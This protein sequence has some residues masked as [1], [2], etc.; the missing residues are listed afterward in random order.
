MS[1]SSVSMPRPLVGRRQGPL[2]QHAGDMALIIGR[3]MNAAARID[4]QLHEVA[5]SAIR[6]GSICR[7]ARTRLLPRRRP[8]RRRRCRDRSALRVHH[9]SSRGAPCR[10]RRSMAKSP[11]RRETSMKQEPERG[12]AIGNST[13][14]SISSASNAVVSAP[15]KKSDA[16]IQRSPSDRLRAQSAAERDRD[17]RHFRG[18]V[19]MR[20]ISADGSAI[21][22]LRVRD[23]RQALRRSSGT[24][25]ATAGSRSSVR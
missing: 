22:D 21:A 17:R 11:R 18:R 25:P 13:S 6:S 2:G 16:S 10:P 5:A 12:C 4:G 23:M 19:G 8:A 3:G 7:P 9:P 24:W 15:T 1:W 20:E 14:T